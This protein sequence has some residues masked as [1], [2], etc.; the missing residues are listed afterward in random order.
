MMTRK[1]ITNV[2]TVV[3]VAMACFAFFGSAHAAMIAYDGFGTTGNLNGTSTG[4]G[5]GGSWTAETAFTLT[6]SGFTPPPA[7]EAV[8]PATGGRVTMGNVDDVDA[9]RLLASSIDMSVD[10]TYY[11]SFIFRTGH[12]DQL[13]LS[14]GADLGSAANTLTMGNNSADNTEIRGSGGWT[15]VAGPAHVATTNLFMVMRIDAVASGTDTARMKVYSLTDTVPTTDAGLSWDATTTTT[16][17]AVYDRIAAEFDW[18]HTSGS[19]FDEVR[20]ATT[21]PAAPVPEPSTLA[22]TTIAM[23]SLGFIGW[24]RRRR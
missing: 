4:T 23:L 21:W 11:L 3:V 15:T 6:S 10:A 9:N 2:W 18:A 13:G 20:F 12:I 14:D 7:V 1:Q 22:L 5:W 16:T 17:S 8:N 19:G 24:R